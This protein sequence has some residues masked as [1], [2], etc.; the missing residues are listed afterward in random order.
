LTNLWKQENL[1]IIDKDTTRVF[2]N[3]ND[4]FLATLQP[5]FPEIQTV[6]D[7][8]GKDD[9]YFY[10][11]NLAEKYRADDQRVIQSGQPFET[12]EVNQ[13]LAGC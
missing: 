5:T 8:V 1:I 13:P 2:I 6:A 12:I 9:F 7:L 4:R 10:P 11:T 3:A